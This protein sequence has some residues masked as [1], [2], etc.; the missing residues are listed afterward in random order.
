MIAFESQPF[1]VLGGVL[2][3]V[4]ILMRRTSQKASQTGASPRSYAREQI[5]RLKDEKGIKTDMEELMVQLQEFAREVN[6]Q[7]DTRF[8]KLEASIRTADERIGQLQRLQRAADGQATVDVT[9]SD[10]K[11]AP[12]P[13][14]E[15]P[16]PAP[17]SQQDLIYGLA[18]AG[19]SVVAIAQET[20]IAA[21]EVELILALR[22]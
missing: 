7:L 22:S 8:A 4:F 10:E 20:G 16:A 13:D 14:Q 18:D 17:A 1:L 3:I 21:G 15:P 9:V 6:G 11:D 5:A 2:V 19:K 12:A